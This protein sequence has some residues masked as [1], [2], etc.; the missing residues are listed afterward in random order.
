MK[1]LQAAIFYIQDF[2]IIKT[3]NLFLDFRKNGQENWT[4]K[5]SE[6]LKDFRSHTQLVI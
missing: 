3:M 6:E 5:C 2:M 1:Q 4:S